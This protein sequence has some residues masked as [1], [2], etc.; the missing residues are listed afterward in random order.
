MSVRMYPEV[1]HEHEK[2]L[3]T[4]TYRKIPVS[5]TL[6][7]QDPSVRVVLEHR[8]CTWFSSGARVWSCWEGKLGMLK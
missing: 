2:N 4:M 3:L 1:L 7:P 8:N 5:C 6:S